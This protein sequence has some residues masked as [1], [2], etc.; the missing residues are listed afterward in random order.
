MPQA[1]QL[2]AERPGYAAPEQLLKIREFPISLRDS[3]KL[4]T[5]PPPLEEN[6][7]GV[8]CLRFKPPGPAR[9]VV[10]HMHGG[11][12]R[13]G[14][15]EMTA[16]LASELAERTAMEI[17]CPDYRLAPE[18]PFPAAILDGYAVFQ[19]LRHEGSLPIVVSGD[20]G[21]GSLASAIV[22]R[23]LDD[24]HP[25]IGLVLLSAWLD[26]TVSAAA[27]DDNAATDPIFAK[28]G[29]LTASDQYRQGVSATDPWVSPYYANVTGFPPTFISIGDGEVL[30]E[31]A[32]GFDQKL[33][34]AGVRT[35]FSL[36]PGMQ[37]TAVARD[38]TLP[39]SAETLEALSDFLVS[40]V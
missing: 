37:H 40:L 9:G 3:G 12:F 8:R 25:V 35:V 1:T 39:G 15:A 30:T 28:P 5:D 21:G 27:F 13:L 36:I 38:L 31:D 18:H 33:R 34:D 23:A 32:T 7:G 17:I 2:P 16:P 29:A 11:G 22:M 6:L 24:G 20:S 26:L 19:A 14:I 4:D 10:L